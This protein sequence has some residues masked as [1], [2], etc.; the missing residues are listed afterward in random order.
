MAVLRSSTK[1]NRA[2]CRYYPM[3]EEL[4]M[5]HNGTSIEPTYLNCFLFLENMMYVTRDINVINC[6]DQ[7]KQ[8]ARHLAMYLKKNYT[9]STPP[10]TPIRASPRNEPEDIPS[11]VFIP[12]SPPMPRQTLF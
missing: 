12:G 5:K 8:V 4:W 9:P 2:P 11:N 7:T 1:Y 10:S 6:D 3:L